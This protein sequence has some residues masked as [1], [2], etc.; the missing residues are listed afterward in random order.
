[1]KV[2]IITTSND[3]LGTTDRNTGVWLEEL[4]TPY[5][6]FKEKGAA[7]S[8]AS[9]NGGE[10][11]LDPKS[12]SIIIATQ[13]SKRFLKDAEAM[14]FIT[15]SIPFDKLH[16]AD[17]DMVLV[18]GGHGALWDLYDNHLLKRLL[19]QFNEEQKPIGLLG[20]GIAS[21]LTL[22][23]NDGDLLIKSMHLTCISD[24]EEESSG[25]SAIIPFLL[26]TR[27]RSAGAVY[28]RT[29]SHTSHLVTDGNFITG[30]NAA[31]SEAVARKM[32]LAMAGAG[33]RHYTGIS[34]VEIMEE[35]L[36]LTNN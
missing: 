15:T 18:T 34:P 33:H 16:S 1:M 31:S 8:I 22:Q 3:K 30:Q 7:I 25:L 28:T 20:Q 27:I 32:L 5:Y 14:D 4:A 10:V 36:P 35:G 23:T 21:L 12:Q 17:F 2:L 19:E 11:P 6:L 24:Q 29:V 26:E 13:Y 9:P